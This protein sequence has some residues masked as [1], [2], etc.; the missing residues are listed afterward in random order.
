MGR[1]HRPTAAPNPAV[2]LS[3][4][5]PRLG[6]LFAA[7]GGDEP[8]LHAELDRLTEGLKPAS[9]LP[10]LVAAF[11]AAPEA[12]RGQLDGQV[13]AWVQARDLLEPLRELEARQTFRD[14]A[15]ALARAWL[16]AGGVALA[17]E[18]SHDPA[19]LF[20]A[21][22]EIGEVSQASPTLFW[23]EDARRRRV[24]SAAF[25]IDFEPPW[26]GACKDISYQSARDLERA[27]GEYSDAWRI[28]GIEPRRLDAATAA[29]R[30]WAALRQNQAQQIRLPADL[31]A[32]LP[33]ILPFLLALPTSPDA[34]PL[35][36]AEVEALATSGRSPES[37]RREEQLYGYQTRM[38]D[39]SV[40]RMIRPP[41]DF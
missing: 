3:S 36:A 17:P 2:R 33:Q 27:V 38:P 9:Y 6:R 16:E 35:S 18:A 22:Y 8:H 12:Q 30:V 29:G 26:E 19:D 32:A 25:L 5:G 31:I 21:A 39:G 37:L 20:L 40:I 24:R 14:P 41:D 10:I 11:A 15:Q 28:H 34:P 23:H 4:L 7:P 13:S 1:K